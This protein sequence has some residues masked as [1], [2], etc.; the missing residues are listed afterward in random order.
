M[1]TI[2]KDAN[3][4]ANE[5]ISSLAPH[6]EESTGEFLTT[7][8]GVKINDDQNSLKA[9]DRGAGGLHSARKDHSL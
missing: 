8:Q 2:K 1:A 6:T 7:N 9:G 5:K 4:V 3:K